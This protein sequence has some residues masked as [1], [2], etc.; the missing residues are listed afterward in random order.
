[1]CPIIYFCSLLNI[2]FYSETLEYKTDKLFQNII[3]VK[4][5]RFE[6][7]ARAIKPSTAFNYARESTVCPTLF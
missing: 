3:C 1:M 5:T 7:K 2:L 6:S 4:I